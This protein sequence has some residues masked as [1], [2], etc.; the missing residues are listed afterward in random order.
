M[1]RRATVYS[2]RRLPA[3]YLEPWRSPFEKL[4][5]DIASPGMTILDVGSGRHPTL[6]VDR[7]PAGVHYVGLDISG[8]ELAAADEGAYDETWI[9]DATRRV[10]DL[11]DR[12]D[13]VVS[14]QVLEHVRPL[15]DALDNFRVYLR[16][17]GRLLAHFSGSFSYFALANRV[18]PHQATAW[19]VDRFTDRPA[20]L[21]FPAHYH[22]CWNSALRRILRS[23]SEVEIVPRYTGATYLRFA[24]P[25]QWLYLIYE[26]WL[27]RTNQRD[28]ATHYLVRARR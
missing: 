18:I 21:V 15:D 24:P 23:W 11:E 25:A 8:S 20:S 26:D 3:R 28:L 7:R 27:V 13:L 16:P 12:F 2:M 17:N 4:L 14:W 10:P 6:P 5:A 1:D 9:A 19:L 22:H